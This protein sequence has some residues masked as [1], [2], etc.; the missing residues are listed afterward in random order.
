[1]IRDTDWYLSLVPEKAVKSREEAESFIII[2]RAV[3]VTIP[4]NEND[5][6]LGSIY[7][8]LVERTMIENIIAQVNVTEDNLIPMQTTANPFTNSTPSQVRMNHYQGKLSELASNTLYFTHTAEEVSR[9]FNIGIEHE[10]TA[11]KVTTQRGI[12]HT[13]HPLHHR[14]QVDHMQLNQRRLNG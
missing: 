8:I 4:T 10:K 1:M 3:R 2:E 14:Y 6:V 7:D 11:I 5:R 9:K 12:C 13:V